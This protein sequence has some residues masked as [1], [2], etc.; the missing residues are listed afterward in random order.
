MALNQ[1]SPHLC[2]AQRHLQEVVVSSFRNAGHFFLQL[3]HH[4]TYSLLS[5]LQECMDHTYKNSHAPVV[6]RDAPMGL[7]C[8]APYEDG[9]HRV[10]VT[11]L[12]A[13]D[14]LEVKY[15]DYGDLA[16]TPRTSLRQIRTDFFELPWQAVEVRLA[17]VVPVNARTHGYEF[18]SETAEEMYKLLKDKCVTS[19]LVGYSLDGLPLVNLYSQDYPEEG[20]EED[21]AVPEPVLVNRQLVDVGLAQWVEQQV[22]APE[23]PVVVAAAAAQQSS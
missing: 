20:K 1:P 12:G 17:N 7:V 2:F 8:V 21:A 16:T 19:H 10:Q 23:V 9:Y 22:M 6:P 18:A 3:P 14:T 15:L 11:A 13:D 5:R 4:Y